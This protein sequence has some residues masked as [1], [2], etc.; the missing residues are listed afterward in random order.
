M[1]Y[2]NSI[3]HYIIPLKFSIKF[4]D[5]GIHFTLFVVQN[6]IIDEYNKAINF[7]ENDFFWEE[8]AFFGTET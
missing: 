5:K 2:H 3:V 7:S 8:K 1:V 4:F 6:L